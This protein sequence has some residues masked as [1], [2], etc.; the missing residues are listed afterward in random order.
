MP[1]R[2]EIR[3]PVILVV[4]D[5]AIL[6]LNVVDMVE[7]AGFEGVEAAD[8]TQAVLILESRLDICIVFTDIDLP[9]GLDGV[10][11]AAIVR[12]RWPPIHIILTSG[13][14]PPGRQDLPSGA[15]FFP[16]PIREKEVVAAMWKLA[17]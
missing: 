4:E 3:R 12:D 7:D 8:A 15:L 17:A 9:G 6:R 1:N 5:E 11:L 16:K 10:R 14:V 2:N 13:H